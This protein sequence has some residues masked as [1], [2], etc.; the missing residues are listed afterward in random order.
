MKTLFMSFLL[1]ISLFSSVVHADKPVINWFHADF[2][3]GFINTGYLKGEGYENYLERYLRQALSEYEHRYYKANYSRILDEIRTENACCVALLRKPE[4]ESFVAYSQPTMLALP[5]GVMIL[6]DRYDEFAPFVDQDGYISIKA[7]FRDSDLRMGVS[8]G[9][10]YGGGVDELLSRFGHH[11][12]IVVRSG[13]DVLR[14]LLKMIAS[15]RSIDYAIGYPHELN[16]LNYK[17]K[18]DGDLQFIP[19]REMPKFVISQIG[20]SKN[21]WGNKVIARLNDVLGGEYN[22]EYKRRYQRFLPA[23]MIALHEQYIRDVFSS[24]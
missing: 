6:R 5:N 19:I 10:R 4:R 7:L 18:L 1:A 2:P 17:E 13:D 9:R 12:K 22:D 16:W 20:C 3:P 14:G 23:E 8:A 21:E 11:P 24:D 15:Q